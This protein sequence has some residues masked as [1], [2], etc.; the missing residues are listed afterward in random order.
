MYHHRQTC[1]PAPS[2]GQR[3]RRRRQRL[4]RGLRQ[5]LTWL[6]LCALLALPWGAWRALD[7]LGQRASARVSAAASDRADGCTSAPH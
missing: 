1:C 3:A 7:S 2:A 5:A 4:L 6:G